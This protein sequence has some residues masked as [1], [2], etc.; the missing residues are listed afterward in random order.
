MSY[1]VNHY[2]DIG[3]THAEEDSIR[4]LPPRH[5]KN[6]MKKIN[7]LVIRTTKTGKIGMSK[8][9]LN[10]LRTMTKLSTYRQY[11]IKKIFYSDNN[12]D[13]VST[14]LKKLYECD[15]QHISRFYHKQ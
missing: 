11:V 12:G 14:T 8:P 4:N 6:Y 1:G 5:R 3:T 10:C 9:C 13:I 2:N 15:N 7:I